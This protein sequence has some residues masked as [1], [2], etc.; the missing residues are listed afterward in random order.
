MFYFEFH[1][2]FYKGSHRQV[3]V[4]S[5]QSANSRLGPSA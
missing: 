1:I 2:N 5:A 3:N 4:C